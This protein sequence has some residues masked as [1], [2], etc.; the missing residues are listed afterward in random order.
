MSRARLD[1]SSNNE[2]PFSADS[3]LDEKGVTA[4]VRDFLSAMLEYRPS[5]PLHFAADFFKA[6][7]DAEDE[8]L[9]ALMS[10]SAASSAG[11]PSRK[12]KDASTTSG[13]AAAAQAKESVLQ[14][15]APRSLSTLQYMH[16][17]LEMQRSSSASD[18]HNDPRLRELLADSFDS[19]AIA[20]AAQQPGLS[21]PHKSASLDDLV[22][23]IKRLA[24]DLDVPPRAAEQLIRELSSLCPSGRC[25]FQQFLGLG[26]SLAMLPRFLSEASRLCARLNGAPSPNRPAGGGAYYHANSVAGGGGTPARR[27]GQGGEGGGEVDVE[28]VIGVL[29]KHRNALAELHDRDAGG[30]GGSGGGG[31]D[32]ALGL[33]ESLI[34]MLGNR[35]GG[36]GGSKQ[37]IDVYD[38]ISCAVSSSNSEKH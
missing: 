27:G 29:P 31:G 9:D 19:L 1:S 37:Q 38:L 2:A 13:V 22:D 21:A 5:Q 20:P 6:L 17:R 28:E 35:R 24:S 16:L 12:K 15:P 23:L 18:R 11:A 33:R 34:L 26:R 30:R 3:F 14:Q 36:G 7:A 25:T 32:L 10:S 8:R 4:S